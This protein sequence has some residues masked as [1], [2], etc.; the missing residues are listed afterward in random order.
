MKKYIMIL[1]IILLAVSSMFLS[2]AEAVESEGY[3]LATTIWNND[4]LRREYEYNKKNVFQAEALAAIFPGAGHRYAEADEFWR[5][6]GIGIVGLAVTVRSNN[7][8]ST[9]HNYNNYIYF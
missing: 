1:L 2:E 4:D 6:L 3:T 7:E 9:F 8:D 5:W